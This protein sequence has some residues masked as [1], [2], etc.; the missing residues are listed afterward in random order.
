MSTQTED[1]Q[2]RLANEGLYF[3]KIDGIDGPKT[4]AALSSRQSSFD[5]EKYLF[6]G[7]TWNPTNNYDF[8]RK[9]PAL[10]VI[11]YTAC[12]A[13]VAIHG[14]KRQRESGNR[15]AHYVIDIKGSITQ[16]VTDT[17]RA[18]HAGKSSWNGKSDCNSYSV[19]IELEN[20]G[21]IS[22]IK[23]T[24]YTH[25][26]DV[27]VGPVDERNGKLWHS[28]DWV[29]LEACA[30]LVAT[31]KVRHGIQEVVGHEHISPMRKIDPGPAFPWDYFNELT[32]EYES[33]IKEG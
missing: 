9:K 32:A 7:V 15:S 20:F 12:P 31:L 21:P 5:D 26:G 13:Y 3:G 28:Y 25:T 19:G 14:F 18:W 4:Q 22:A 6:S 30:A 1:L 29:Q 11:H 16:L 17:H 24:L 27:F 23:N 8:K 2:R 33:K 10:I